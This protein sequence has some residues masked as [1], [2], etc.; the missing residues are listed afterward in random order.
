MHACYLFLFNLGNIFFTLSSTWSTGPEA[1]TIEVAATISSPPAISLP[2]MAWPRS[3]TLN[4]TAVTGSRAPNIA[5]GVEPIELIATVVQLSESTV[6]KNA[7]A[8][9]FIHDAAV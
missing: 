7:R 8:T 2:V 3:V 4:T 6:G 9:R 1:T 5:V